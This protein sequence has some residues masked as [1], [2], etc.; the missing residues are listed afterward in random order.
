MIREDNEIFEEAIRYFSSILTKFLNLVE[1]GQ[2]III[3]MIPSII[4]EA[5]NWA[6]LAIPKM[7]EIK[8]AIFYLPIEKAPSPD[9]F[10]TFFF[11]IY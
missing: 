9:G 2:N 4:N 11:Q 6:L 1:E 10:S 5:Q 8:E 3:D 7:D